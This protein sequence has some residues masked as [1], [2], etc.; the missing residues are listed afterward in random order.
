MRFFFLTG[1]TNFT[2]YG[3]KWISNKQSNGEFDYYFVIELLNWEETVGNEAPKETYNV[4]L[5][6]VSPQ[7]AEE[8]IARAMDCCGIT[9]EMLGAANGYR[10]HA[11]VEALHSYGVHVPVWSKDGNNWRKLIGE[12]RQEAMGCECM[13]GFYM[14]RPVNRIGTT[15]WEFLRGDLNSALNRV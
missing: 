12:A 8:H 3:G 10:D 14:D 6:V 15:G 11:L 2:T 4:T 7:E 1:D 13:F 9:E 5:S